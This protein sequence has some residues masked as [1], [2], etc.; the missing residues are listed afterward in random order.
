MACSPQEDPGPDVLDEG[1]VRTAKQARDITRGFLSVAA[2]TAGSGAEAVLLVVSELFANAV[3]HA[4]GVTGFRLEAGPEAVTVAV[5]VD[6]ASTAPPRP[7]P[8]DPW[9]PGGFGWH[10]V[11]Q[12]SADVQVKNCATGKTVSATVHAARRAGSSSRRRDGHGRVFSLTGQ[13]RRW[14]NGV[15]GRDPWARCPLGGTADRQR[16]TDPSRWGVFH[17][18]AGQRPA[19]E[20]VSISAAPAGPGLL[21]KPDGPDSPRRR[22]AGGAD[23]LCAR[24]DDAQRPRVAAGTRPV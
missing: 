23:R 16:R 1:R 8:L 13:Q 4:G 3:R 22:A 14:K 17:P 2:P 11:R 24:A 19:A 20:Q 5:A 12:L 15:R 18:V 10:L 6:D 9:T 21:R 7:R